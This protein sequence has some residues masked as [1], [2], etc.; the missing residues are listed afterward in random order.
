M[1]TAVVL[2]AA[3]A[4]GAKVHVFCSR[5]SSLRG[6]RFRLARTSLL[7]AA[8]ARSAAAACGSLQAS[9]H[10]AGGLA[11]SAPTSRRLCCRGAGS[12]PAAATSS[13]Q[14][15]SARPWRL[16]WDRLLFQPPP[17]TRLPEAAATTDALWTRPRARCAGRAAVRAR[18]AVAPSA[19]SAATRLCPLIR[20]RRSLPTSTTAAAASAATTQPRIL[21]AAAAP[22]AL[23]SCTRSRAFS[24]SPSLALEGATTSA[25]RSTSA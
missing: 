9:C 20:P 23:G 18:P 16:P 24:A 1:P 5:G 2:W 14:P 8:R 10:A 11:V 12:R 19:A 22:R 3:S 4:S 13:C 15:T 7:I 21:G 17:A 25:T 6:G